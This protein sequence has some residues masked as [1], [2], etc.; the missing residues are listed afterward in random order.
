MS[1]SY[2]LYL[3]EPPSR[4][5]DERVDPEAVEEQRLRELHRIDYLMR[6]L[7]EDLQD[8][9]PEGYKV[10]VVKEPDDRE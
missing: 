6:S 2:S 10:A 9:L 3:S 1:V 8:L 4:I 7:A 5:L